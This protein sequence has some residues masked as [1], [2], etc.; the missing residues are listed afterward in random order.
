MAS[1][2]LLITFALGTFTSLQ[3]FRATGFLAFQTDEAIMLA[4]DLDGQIGGFQT[5]F[6]GLLHDQFHLFELAR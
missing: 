6:T 2:D 4:S 5:D 1:P 3:L